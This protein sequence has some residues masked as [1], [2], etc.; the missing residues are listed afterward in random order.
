MGK[1][2]EKVSHEL[3]AAAG[4]KGEG[5]SLKPRSRQPAALQLYGKDQPASAASAAALQA[6]LASPCAACALTSDR[7]QSLFPLP[8]CRVAGR[9]LQPALGPTH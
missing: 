2:V 5:G 6:R 1:N 7:K 9:T 4:Y 3:G 8:A